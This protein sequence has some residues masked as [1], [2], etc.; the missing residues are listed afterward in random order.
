MDF[1]AVRLFFDWIRG[2]ISSFNVYAPIKNDRGSILEV[3]AV[4]DCIMA[5][6]QPGK[7]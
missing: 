5:K 2:V 7:E 1:L 4:R 6:V 3:L